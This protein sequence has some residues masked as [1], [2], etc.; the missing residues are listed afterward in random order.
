[1]F[2]EVIFLLTTKHRTNEVG[3]PIE[4]LQKTMR[5]ATL[6]SI[7]QAEFYQAQAQGLKPEIKF[8]LADYL[9]YDNQ[10]E[11]IY[12]NFRY[13]VLR[14]FRNG[15]ELEITCY[16]GIRLEVVEDGNS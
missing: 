14:T 1:M 6:K 8:V 2:N 16:G 12:N 5:F 7:G 13:K 3:D 4:E 9:D 11:I 10:E 15:N